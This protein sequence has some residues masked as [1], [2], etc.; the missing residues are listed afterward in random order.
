[1][2]E[3]IEKIKKELKEKEIQ[4]IYLNFVDFT[5]NVLTKMVG[6]QE[7]INLGLM[8]LVLMGI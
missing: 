6:V 5:G 1:M 3:Q 7:L 2:E 4:N 8:V